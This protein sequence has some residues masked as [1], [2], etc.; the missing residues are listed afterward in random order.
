MKLRMTR[1]GGGR[2]PLDLKYAPCGLWRGPLTDDQVSQA[3]AFGTESAAAGEIAIQKEFLARF[4]PETQMMI[5]VSTAFER[6]AVYVA[7]Q[8][9]RSEV[10]DQAVIESFRSNPIFETH[11]ALDIVS[12]HKLLSVLRFY[13][14]GYDDE[15][16][17]KPYPGS[18]EKMKLISRSALGAGSYRQVVAFA[19]PPKLDDDECFEIAIQRFMFL[20]TAITRFEVRLAWYH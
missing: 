16:N 2:A 6:I 9:Y 1:P 15:G 13:M 19:Y 20:S 7:Q 3:I 14:V 4:I 8:V 10:I 11:Y 17:P 5:S 18:Y 12:P